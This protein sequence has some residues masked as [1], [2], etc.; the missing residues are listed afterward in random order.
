[1]WE[2]SCIIMVITDAD[3]TLLPMAPRTLADGRLPFTMGSTDSTTYLTNCRL[4]I[5]DEKLYRKYFSTFTS[6]LCTEE[7]IK[8]IVNGKGRVGYL[9]SEGIHHVQTCP[10]A[11]YDHQSADV[12]QVASQVLRKQ[13]QIVLQDN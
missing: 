3:L 8:V 11:L 7:C 13:Q 5:I 9:G 10:D 2:K 1:M 4:F 6:F 12:A